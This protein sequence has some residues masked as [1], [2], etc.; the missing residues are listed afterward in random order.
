MPLLQNGSGDAGRLKL[1]A[2]SSTDDGQFDPFSGTIF[3]N[4]KGRSAYIVSY[5]EMVHAID[6]AKSAGMPGF[7]ETS[8]IKAYNLHSGKVLEEARKSLGLRANQKTYKDM[9]FEVFDYSTDLYN[10]YSNNPSEV[11]AYALDREEREKSNALSK[12]QLERF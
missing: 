11:V 9:L 4:K 7:M 2:N 10:K 8:G 6:A 5:H 12:A 1:I 3:L